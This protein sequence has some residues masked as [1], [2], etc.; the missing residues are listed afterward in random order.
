MK[1]GAKRFLGF[2]KAPARTKR[3]VTD[4]FGCGYFR[5]NPDG[6]HEEREDNRDQSHGL[7]LAEFGCFLFR[8]GLA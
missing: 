4:C 3:H 7:I 1:R 6:L 5:T 8:P 2:I